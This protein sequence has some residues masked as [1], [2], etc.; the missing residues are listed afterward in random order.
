MP[1][2]VITKNET[3]QIPFE[4]IVKQ[5]AVCPYY[6]ILLSIKKELLIHIHNF[7]KTADYYA[8][9][10]KSPKECMIS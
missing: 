10:I 8:K 6:K 4:L 3:V 5:T 7:N 9:K 1:L 2:L